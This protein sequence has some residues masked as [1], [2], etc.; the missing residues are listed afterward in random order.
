[1]LENSK[2]LFVQGYN[3]EVH[4]VI[5]YMEKH[6]A[7]V[8]ISCTSQ[9]FVWCNKQKPLQDTVTFEGAI[10]HLIKGLKKNKEGE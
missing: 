9:V 2:R 6:Y 4:D 7:A 8:I 5:K 1:M 3:L 10:S